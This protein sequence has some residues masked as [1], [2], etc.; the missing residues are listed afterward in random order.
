MRAL[1]F[2]DLFRTWAEHVDKMAFSLFLLDRL[3]QPLAGLLKINT[4]MTRMGFPCLGAWV[5]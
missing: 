2:S 1:G 5:T 4:G 3:E